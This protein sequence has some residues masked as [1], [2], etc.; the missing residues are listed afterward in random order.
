MVLLED[1]GL[2]SAQAGRGVCGVVVEQYSLAGYSTSEPKLLTSHVELLALER[3]HSGEHFEQLVV[4]YS[5]HE[6]VDLLLQCWSS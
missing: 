2:W 5:F 1:G 4:V 3:P 6:R